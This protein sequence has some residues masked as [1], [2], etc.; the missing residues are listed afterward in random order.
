M[1]IPL[2]STRFLAVLPAALLVLAGCSRPASPPPGPPEVPAEAAPAGSEPVPVEPAPVEAAPAPAAS[3]SAPASHPASPKPSQPTSGS[4]GASNSS[5][6]GAE[7]AAVGEPSHPAPRMLTLP[8]GKRM[9]IDLDNAL[10]TATS[11]KGDSFS[12]TVNKTEHL[13]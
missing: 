13:Y 11:K 8:A 5:T 4:T 2:R 6:T 3:P 10:S 9:K 7:D 1:T 12:V